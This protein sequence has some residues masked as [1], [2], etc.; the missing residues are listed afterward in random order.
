MAR[1]TGIGAREVFGVAGC[2]GA[3]G[4]AG[5][6]SADGA[7]EF[8]VGI[9]DFGGVEAPA[10]APGVVTARCTLPAP[11]PETGAAPP[12]VTGRLSGSVTLGPTGSLLP[13][14]SG[15]CGESEPVAGRRCTAGLASP[16][17]ATGLLGAAGTTSRVS[18]APSEATARCTATRPAT[19]PPVP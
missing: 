4:V 11:F 15:V 16:G 7:G 18:P 8:G 14:A 2:A 5:D 17:P 19:F 10:V 9:V 3:A 12:R 6:N 13:C 1:C